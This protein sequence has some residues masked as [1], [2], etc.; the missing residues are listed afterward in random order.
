MYLTEIMGKYEDQTLKSQV[1]EYLDQCK[2]E[3]DKNV[4]KFRKS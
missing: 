1:K 2:Q 4:E 3:I